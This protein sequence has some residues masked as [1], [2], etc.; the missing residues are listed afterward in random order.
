METLLDALYRHAQENLVS[1]YLQ[2]AEYRRAA[3]TVETD[4]EQFRSTLT[5]EQGA[6]LD[7]LLAREKEV[8]RL[9]D[10]AAFSCALSMGIALGRL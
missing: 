4:W 8:A 6:R 1:R 3:S 5:L 2:T 9:E 7:A 10:E